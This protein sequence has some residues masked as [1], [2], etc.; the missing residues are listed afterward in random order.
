MVSAIIMRAGTDERFFWN[1]SHD[2]G[3]GC[4]N[5]MDDVELVR[6]G[7]YCMGNNPASGTIPP[8]Q[9]AR[10]LGLSLSGPFD[11]HL[12]AVIRDH[13]AARGGVQDGKVSTIKNA[14]GYYGNKSWIMVIL[15]NNMMDILGE[16]WP[17]ID[18]HHQTSALLTQKIRGVFTLPPAN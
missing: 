8:A 7:Y 15:N 14:T 11:S 13:Q 6:F 9:K 3:P 2:V 10:L 4:P 12:A 16:T 5:Q 1:L 18:R 17:R